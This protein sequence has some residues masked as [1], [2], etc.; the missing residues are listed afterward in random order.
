MVFGGIGIFLQH[1]KDWTPTFLVSSISVN[2]FNISIN[3]I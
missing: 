3:N 2:I 1:R